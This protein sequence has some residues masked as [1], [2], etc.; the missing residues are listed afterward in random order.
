MKHPAWLDEG[1]VD[2]GE[3]EAANEY[4]T[5][6][7]RSLAPFF[8]PFTIRTA[9]YTEDRKLP[10]V[11]FSF[12]QLERRSV[13]DRYED[14]LNKSR[15]NAL[16]DMNLEMS[17]LMTTTNN[18]VTSTDARLEQMRMSWRKMVKLVNKWNASP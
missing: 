11:F 1:F 4:L 15:I 9:L 10:Q 18:T 13:Y 12:Y 16:A 3:Y 6:L 7:R 5:E 8:D 14:R 17:N 2:P